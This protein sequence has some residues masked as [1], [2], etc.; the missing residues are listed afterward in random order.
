VCFSLYYR[1]AGRARTIRTVYQNRVDIG[2]AKTIDDH[3]PAI[4]GDGLGREEAM[5]RQSIA[6]IANHLQSIVNYSI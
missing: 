1:L 2:I 4:A 5:K 6:L 3:Q